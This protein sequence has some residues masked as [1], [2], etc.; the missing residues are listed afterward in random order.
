MIALGQFFGKEMFSDVKVQF[1]NMLQRADH[2]CETEI[3]FLIGR[4][5]TTARL[6]QHKAEN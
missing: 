1:L 4:K 5:Q 3:N 2:T 6:T